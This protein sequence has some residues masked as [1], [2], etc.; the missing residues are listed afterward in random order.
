LPSQADFIN[1]SGSGKNCLEVGLPVGWSAPEFPSL[2]GTYDYFVVFNRHNGIGE[3]GRVGLF[4]SSSG[5][6][7]LERRR[8]GMPFFLLDAGRTQFSGIMAKEI[9]SGTAVF[10]KLHKFNLFKLRT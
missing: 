2:F 1:P 4:C 3:K 5:A 8:W 9:E 6:C 7:R 10:A